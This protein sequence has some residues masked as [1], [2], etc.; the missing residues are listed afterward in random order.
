MAIVRGAVVALM[1]GGMTL[2]G[3]GSLNPLSR[4]PRAAD[5]AETGIGVNAFL[6]RASLDTIGFMPLA[7]ADAFGGVILTDWYAPP[8]SPNERFKMTVMIQDR[9]LR[10]DA[11]RVSVFR[12]VQNTAGD[13]IDSPVD[14]KTST[15]MENAILT[16]ARELRS[17]AAAAK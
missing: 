3:C 11:I 8:E 14:Q 1:I 2:S 10:A 4:A 15:D 13:W 6:W 12:Q 7:S 17:A 5:T 16:R 9:T